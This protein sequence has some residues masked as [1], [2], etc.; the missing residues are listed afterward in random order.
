ML[1]QCLYV[2]LHMKSALPYLE[3]ALLQQANGRIQGHHSTLLSDVA[4]QPRLV[5]VCKYIPVCV[6][7]AQQGEVCEIH[8][9]EG[10][11]APITVCIHIA[12]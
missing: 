2:R 7:A 11:F 8:C 6:V 12:F 9:I 1:W 4:S 10:G 3:G 5:C